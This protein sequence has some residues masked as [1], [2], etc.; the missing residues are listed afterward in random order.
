[1]AEVYTGRLIGQAKTRVVARQIVLVIPLARIGNVHCRQLLISRLY[2]HPTE[3]PYEG[4]GDPPCGTLTTVAKTGGGRA[5]PNAGHA[6]LQIRLRASVLLSLLGILAALVGAAGLPR[7]TWGGHGGVVQLSRVAAGPYVV[8]VWTQPSPPTPGPWRVDV[9][10]MHEG[11]VAVTDA[12]VRVRAESL[13]GAAMPVE[14][15]A[16]READPLGVRYRANL[17]LGAAG[18]WRVSVSV[19]GP[20]GP[21]ALTFPVDV[22]PPRP[23]W[24]GLAALGAGGLLIL[25]VFATL[26]RRFTAAALGVLLVTTTAWPH[27][28]LVRS[29]PARRATLTAAPDRVQLWF[30]EAIEPRFSG[31]SVWNA[32]GEQVDLGNA[33]VE[34]ED[35]KRLTVGLKPLERGAYRVRF[36]VL[37]VDGH[38]VESE[39]PFTLRP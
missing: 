23:G 30:N 38:V 27:A 33:R 36:R 2:F 22:E 37:S 24:W 18:P 28:A 19:S 17:T 21:G 34:P 31:V 7:P 39:F 5:S 12:V 25:T 8:S 35:P 1:M 26:R 15:D 20:A 32:A 13:Q 3:N 16:L 29:T 14:T 9:A 6:R 11:G 4:P 10:V